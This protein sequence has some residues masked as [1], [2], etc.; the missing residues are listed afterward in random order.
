MD[1]IFG[2]FSWRNK[3]YK[4]ALQ[5]CEDHL[6]KYFQ[7][8]RHLYCITGDKEYDYILYSRKYLMI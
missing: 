8:I 1:D 4:K 3:D 2:V 5:E 7:S 6:V